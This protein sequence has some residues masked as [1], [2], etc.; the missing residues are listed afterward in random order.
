MHRAL[1]TLRFDG[2][3]LPFPSVGVAF[4]LGVAIRGD[5]DEEGVVL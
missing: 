5:V 3:L 4:S 1:L 2:E